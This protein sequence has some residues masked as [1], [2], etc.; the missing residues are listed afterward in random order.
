MLRIEGL[1]TG[2]E[3]KQVL[4]DISLEIDKGDIALLIGSNGSG[5]STLLKSI[6]G[7]CR[8]WEGKIVFDN[9]DITNT[10]TEKLLTKGLAYIPQKNNVFEQLTVKENIE[11][12]GLALNNNSLFKNRLEEILNHFPVFQSKLKE[13]P[14][15]MS[16]GERQQLVLAMALIHRPKLLLI[17][18]PFTGLT[19]QAI[20]MISTQI[21]NLNRNYNTTIL[22]VEHRI[23]EALPL[24]NQIFGLKLGKIIEHSKEPSKFTQEI[25]NQVLI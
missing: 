12:S 15:K 16:G 8:A 22:M 6:Y 7:I 20:Q 10:P 13:F 23:S 19:P 17:D 25:I 2:Y 14:M 18:E 1:N 11:I 4:F 9:E 21:Q 3:K 24:S 5:K